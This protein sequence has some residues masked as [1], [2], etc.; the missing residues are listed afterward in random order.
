MVVLGFQQGFS[1]RLGQGEGPGAVFGRQ[2]LRGE[3]RS[4]RRRGGGRGVEGEGRPSGGGGLGVVVVAVGK[5]GAAAPGE[6]PDGF[7]PSVIPA[8]ARLVFCLLRLFFFLL[9]FDPCDTPGAL[10]RRGGPAVAGERQTPSS[11]ALRALASSPLSVA[12][13]GRA[14]CR[15]ADTA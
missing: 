2:G 6:D 8:L 11:G 3:G 12:T 4:E 9:L 5:E 15:T 13:L 1:P 14:S 10:C 7:P